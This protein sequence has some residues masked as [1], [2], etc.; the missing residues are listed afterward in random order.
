[1]SMSTFSHVSCYVVIEIPVSCVFGESESSIKS[2]VLSTV[3]FL[4]KRLPT[5][6]REGTQRKKISCFC[7]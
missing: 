4:Q 3:C 7:R 2:Q 6:G 1:V 5:G